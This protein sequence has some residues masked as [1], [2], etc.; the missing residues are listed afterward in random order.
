ME[1]LKQKIKTLVA[2]HKT[3]ITVALTI[4]GG[5]I[6]GRKIY[7]AGAQYGSMLTALTLNDE[8]P[9][10]NILGKYREVLKRK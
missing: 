6:I 2:E 3:G 9:E 4:V 1:T 5:A 8:L 7:Y 10:A